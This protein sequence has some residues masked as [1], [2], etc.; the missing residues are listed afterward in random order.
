M[1]VHKRNWDAAGRTLRRRIDLAQDDQERF[2]L[3]MKTGDLYANHMRD[4]DRA[5]KAY[6]TALELNAGDRNLLSKLMALYSEAKD[7]TRLLEVLVRMA[8][9]VDEPALRGKY[10]HTAASVA[11]QEL[12]AFDQAIE[13][14]EKALA[15]VP[16]LDAAF[17]G[18]ADCMQRG[19]D[20]QG[21]ARAYRAQIE[22]TKGQ[23]TRRAARC[24][25]GQA[26]PSSTTIASTASTRRSWLM[27]PHRTSIP[28][29]VS[30]RS[31]WSRSTASTPIATPSARSGP[32]LRC[33]LQNP[34]RIESY[35]GLRKLYTQLSRPDEA[36]A[37][38]QALRSLNMAEPDE[39]AFFKRHRVQAP[40]TARECIT[41]QIW[42]EYII[43]SEQDALLT[44][45]F[46]MIQPAAV[47]ELAQEPENFGIDRTAPIDCQSESA[48]MSQM[49]FYASGVTLVPLPPV[50][51]QPASGGGASFL[52]TNPPSIG[53]GQAAFQSAPDQALAFIA[54][55][56]LSY[57]RPGH[58]MR[59]LVPTG[60]G[61]RS[62]LLAAIRLA[63]PR[64]PVPDNMRAQVERNHRALVSMLHGPTQQTLTSLV[65]KLLKEQPELDMKRWAMAVDVTAD[66][67]GF[68]LANSLDAAVAVVRASP[69]DSSYASE[70][71]RLK[72]LYLYAVSPRYLALR[73]A[74]GV[75][76]A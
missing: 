66:R 19:G 42:E 70:R 51:Y 62:W 74:I 28:R 72:E 1:Q 36:W 52:F 64:F 31:A 54:G 45:I 3:W 63:N 24:S 11:Q 76:I 20:W 43:S 30:A 5:A 59:Q 50:F 40:A 55:R 29:T 44:S 14:Y 35:R 16:T 25:L 21:L 32:T 4:R 47:S 13:Y 60:S 9:V 27:K 38:C 48:V 46:A 6:V 34:Y 37:V 71:D 65:D 41:E 26:W 61:L 57:M 17:R 7:W 69:A 18:L 56:Q 10:F 67:V 12:G 2:G 58:Y 49:L 39:E 75:T 15:S 8:G 68:V 73:Q 33:S 23:I 53:L 22:R